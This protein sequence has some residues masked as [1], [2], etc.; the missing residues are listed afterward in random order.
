ML[1][2]TMA[3]TSSGTKKIRS[4]VRRLGKFTRALRP[5]CGKGPYDKPGM[6]FPQ[7]HSGSAARGI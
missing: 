3:D 6:R 5:F 4:S 1:S 7:R 2:C